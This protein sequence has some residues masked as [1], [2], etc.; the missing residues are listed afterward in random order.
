[1][2]RG[3]FD[4]VEARVAGAASR[5]SKRLHGRANLPLIESDWLR[6]VVGEAD[7]GRRHRNPPAARFGNFLAAF[8]RPGGAALS[9]RVRQLNSCWGALAVDESRN[10]R[11]HFN[12][13]V[14]PKPQILGTDAPFGKNSR[15]FREDERSAANGA[16]A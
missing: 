4:H 3:D 15:C 1:M 11:E 5:I 2:S 10:A 16:T 6:I 9:T 12:V 14:F 13:L 7:I 8:P